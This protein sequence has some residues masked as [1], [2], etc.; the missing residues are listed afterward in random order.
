MSKPESVLKNVVHKI[1]WDFK[2]QTNHSTQTQR[3]DLVL[4]NKKKRIC[5]LVVVKKMKF[6][7]HIQFVSMGHGCFCILCQFVAFVYNVINSPPPLSLSPHSR[8]LLFSCELTISVLTM[9]IHV[10]VV[11]VPFR[12]YVKV[13]S[14]AISLVCRLKYPYSCFSSHFSC[15]Q[16][17]L[18]LWLVPVAVIN[19]LSALFI[20]SSSP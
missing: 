13:I 6:K 11:L 12:S 18:W 10:G 20:Y 9:L 8:Y 1:L 2:I 3:P 7:L 17:F 14:Y 15:L 5:Y 16:S 19:S 4:I